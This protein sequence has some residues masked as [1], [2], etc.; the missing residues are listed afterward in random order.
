M[1]SGVITAA[2]ALAAI[3]F[4]DT[5]PVR[6]ETQT[7]TVRTLP[8]RE[9]VACVVTSSGLDKKSVVSPAKLTVEKSWG[10]IDIHCSKDCLEGSASIRPSLFGGYPS[11][12]KV[13]LKPI[14]NC[15]PKR[16]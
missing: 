12:T 7:I 11:E 10:A 5:M 15:A 1:Q 13:M 14:K 16:R 4:A 3:I 2:S 9:G 8:I 6:A